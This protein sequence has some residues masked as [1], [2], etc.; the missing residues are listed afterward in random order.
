MKK[1]FPFFAQLDQKD[2]GTACLKMVAAY[3]GKKFTSEYLNEIAFIG[4]DGITL[5]GMGRAAGTIGLQFLAANADYEMLRKSAPLPCILHWKK[6]HFV[7]LYKIEKE[8]VIVADPAI[9]LLSYSK[10]DFIRFWIGAGASDTEE[11]IVALLEPGTGFLEMDLNNKKT[12]PGLL[13]IIHF[14]RPHKKLLFHLI[15]GLLCSS[16]FALFIPMFTQSLV[17][18][19][20]NGENISFIY[21]ILIA[22]LMF[23][24][25]KISLEVIKSWILLFISMRISISILSL[26]FY[27]LMRLPISFF[28]S[29]SFGDIMQRVYDNDRIKSLLT[30]SSLDVIFSVFNLIVFSFVL[31]HYDALILAV[32][33]G[34]SILYMAW[35]L[36]FLSRRKKIDHKRF[37]Q[38]AIGHNVELEIVQGI[39]EIKIN[40][41]EE[42]LQGDWEKSQASIFSVRKSS[43][44]LD[45]IQNVGGTIINEVRNILIL[46]LA[47][48]EVVRGNMTLGMMMASQQISGQLSAPISQLMNFAREAQDA[49]ISMERLVEIHSVNAEDSIRGNEL[50]DTIKGE[51]IIFDRVTFS[52]NGA[53]TENT[54]SDVSFTIPPFKTTAIVGFSGSGKT[55]ILKLLLKL[56]NPA[57]G[58]IFIGS[59]P[60]RELNSQSWRSRCGVV[61]QNGHIFSG[62]IATNIAMGDEEVAAGKL[63]QAAEI[64]NIKEFILSLPKGY[65]TRIGDGGMDLSQGQKQRILIARAVY[66]NPD[67][68]FFDEATSSLDTSNEREISDKIL[69]ISKGKTLVVIAHRLSTIKNADQIIVVQGG[70]IKEK[71][72]HHS[73]SKKRGVYYELVK[74]QME[75]EG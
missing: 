37:H 23:M 46:F 20:V 11:G 49:K 45:Q 47:A 27:K 16:I 51:P 34:G 70:R 71:G 42:K 50:P 57:E 12:T 63:E 61:M 18:F 17:D 66:R 10:Q 9:S 32:F 14:L 58:H 44:A 67:F 39:Q 65:S 59:T 15:L 54:L 3:Y 7:V 28:D 41:C 30:Y 8:K 6:K 24:L 31:L 13:S 72:D 62:T 36:Y 35:I 5:E 69:E 53:Q 29:R 55:T 52:Y 4:K 19:G 60:M 1:K 33:L 25:G 21:L 75:L 74:D 2:C 26:F 38:M 68:L 48:N 73:L 56:Y 64:A 43:L 22:Q 40:N